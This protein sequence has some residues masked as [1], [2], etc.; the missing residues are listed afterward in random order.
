VLKL[1]TFE[2]V[3]ALA[4]RGGCVMDV[5]SQQML[6][7]ALTAGRGGVPLQLCKEQ[8]SKLLQAG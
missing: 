6:D 8:Y 3:V 1:A 4:D 2:S 5:Q 7:R